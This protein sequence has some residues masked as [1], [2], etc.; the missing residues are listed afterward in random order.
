MSETP[1]ASVETGPAPGAPIA[2]WRAF[3]AREIGAVLAMPVLA[4]GFLAFLAPLSGTLVSQWLK[5]LFGRERPPLALHA[6]EVAN[7][8]FPSGHAMLSAVVYLTLA[9][10]ISRFT[11]RRAVKTYA[12]AAGV[13]LTLLVGAS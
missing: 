8:S 9:V 5:H 6:V 10:L 7:S 13:A 2:A 1:N 3:L 11:D 12:I 4:G